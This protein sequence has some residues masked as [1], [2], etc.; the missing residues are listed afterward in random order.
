[1]KILVHLSRLLVG[2]IFIYSGFVKLVDPLGSAYKFQE[3]F[4]ED[5]LNLEFLIPYALPFAIFM[6]VAEFVLGIMLLVGFLRKFTVWSL[7]LMMVVF[8]FLTWYSYTYDKVTDC[9]C[10][11]DAIKL[12][13]GETFYKNV[14]LIVFNLILVIGV[15]HIKPVF[16]KGFAGIVTLLALV[17][18][19]FVT[20]HV[21]NHLPIVDFRA[22]SIGTNIPEDMEYKPGSDEEPPIH[23]FSL[24]TEDEDLTETILAQDKVLLIV[25][26]DI[27]KSDFEGFDAIKPIADEAIK[28]GY[29]VY[30][31]SASTTEDTNMIKEDYELPFNFLFADETM[32]KTMIRSNPGIV[33]LHKGTIVGK[34]AWRDAG[35]VFKK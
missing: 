11:G 13:T 18:S 27:Y 23:D 17:G 4:S 29:H 1:M 10:F 26:Y 5:V 3:Y 14:I 19:L 12:T 2:V 15:K 33:E 22:Y 30:G 20:S 24:E 31:L 6:V 32:L 34:W 8:L 16:S 25:S 7:F 28:K 35:D 9:G 21:L